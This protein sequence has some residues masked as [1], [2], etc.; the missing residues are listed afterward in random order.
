MLVVGS[1]A[2]GRKL[3]IIPRL[4][5]SCELRWLVGYPISVPG[6]FRSRILFPGAIE[7]SLILCW[8]VNSLLDEIRVFLLDEK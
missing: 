3:R 1:E 5:P 7:L 2:S 8:Q 6:S 4:T